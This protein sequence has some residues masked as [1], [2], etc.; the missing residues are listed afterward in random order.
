[1]DVFTNFA[2][3]LDPVILLAAAAMEFALVVVMWLRITM[4]RKRLHKA[5]DAAEDAARAAALAVPGGIDP[6]IVISMLRAGHPIS[7]DTIHQLM[8]ERDDRMQG[9]Y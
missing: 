6:D 1:M 7:L 3:G 8:E 4:L 2:H 9:R 5:V